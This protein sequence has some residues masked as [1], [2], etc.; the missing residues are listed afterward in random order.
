MDEIFNVGSSNI[1]S[2]L[3]L[4]I[5]LNKI[6]VSERTKSITCPIWIETNEFDFPEKNWNDLVFL[7]LSMWSKGIVHYIDNKQEIILPFVDG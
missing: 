4:R 6:S 1:Y 5:D 2:M 3:K 7:I